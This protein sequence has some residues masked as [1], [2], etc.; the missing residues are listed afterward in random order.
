MSIVGQT[1]YY[2]WAETDL[3]LIHNFS[4]V[5]FDHIGQQTVFFKSS[6]V[7]GNSLLMKYSIRIIESNIPVFT[8]LPF[9]LSYSEG[10]VGNLISWKA[11]DEFPSTFNIFKDDIMY[12]QV[13]VSRGLE[14]EAINPYL[15][16][17]K[18]RD[19]DIR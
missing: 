12:Q 2:G 10:M 6:D 3:T 1:T 18:I 11:E 5:Y 9:D 7:Y 15:L 16:Q 13:V 4:I 8:D 19:G 14:L 17:G